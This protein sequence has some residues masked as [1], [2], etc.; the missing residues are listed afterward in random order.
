[1]RPPKK[2]SVKSWLITKE[3]MQIRRK[4]PEICFHNISP[5]C[6]GDIVIGIHLNLPLTSLYLPTF[7]VCQLSNNVK[8]L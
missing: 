7:T 1:M 4:I 8:T 3:W 5:H 2:I 6:L